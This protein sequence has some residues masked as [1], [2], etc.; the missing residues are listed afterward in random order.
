M[1]DFCRP[2]VRRLEIHEFNGQSERIIRLRTTKKKE[3]DVTTDKDVRSTSSNQRQAM[4]SKVSRR[5]RCERASL[6]PDRQ[7][8]VPG[9]GG[10]GNT[11]NSRV[12][13]GRKL[14]VRS[15]TRLTHL[16]LIARFGGRLCGRLKAQLSGGRSVRSE[17]QVAAIQPLRCLPGSLKASTF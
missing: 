16:D 6:E 7:R 13:R 17:A 2:S 11:V 14:R 8:C 9:N 15:R 3:S 4:G 5:V 10:T 1:A 12:P